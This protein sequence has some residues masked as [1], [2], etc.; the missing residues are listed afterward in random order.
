MNLVKII[1][2]DMRL[3]IN[4]YKEKLRWFDTVACK[5]DI[6]NDVYE[7]VY[8]PVCFLKKIGVLKLSNICLKEY[9]TI[10]DNQ[11][12]RYNETDFYNSDFNIFFNR[13]PSRHRKE[14]REAANI[15]CNNILLLCLFILLL[16]FINKYNN[17][18]F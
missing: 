16:L 7:K 6:D 1:P 14:Y 10:Q 4:G 15:I 17:K 5:V 2:N 18:T 11:F 9:I 12:A 13:D 8:L 3:S